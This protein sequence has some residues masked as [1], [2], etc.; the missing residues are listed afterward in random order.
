MQMFKERTFKK[1]DREFFKRKTPEKKA[2]EECK[3]DAKKVQEKLALV[4][5]DYNGERCHCGLP[6]NEC[7]RR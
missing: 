2:D 5:Q 6:E 4:S 7:L 3:H 1:K